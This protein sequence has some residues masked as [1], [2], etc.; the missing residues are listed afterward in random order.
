MLYPFSCPIWVRQLPLKQ[1]I[2]GQSLNKRHLC[3]SIK[4]DDYGK[5]LTLAPQHQY[6]V[7]TTS[8]KIWQVVREFSREAASQG[9]GFSRGKFNMTSARREQCNRLQQ[10]CWCRYWFFLLCTP[11]QWLTILFSEPD[12]PKIA[13]SSLRIWTPSNTWF[14]GLTRVRP[15]N[16]ILIGSAV[17]AWLT[18]MTNR[19]TDRHTQTHTQTTLLRLQQQVAFSYCCIVA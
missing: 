4:T 9:C 10:S 11:Q 7:I 3:S 17:L 19:R 14:L 15:R 8:N 1:C 6:S 16:G 5:K 2:L 13:P 18:S 12:N